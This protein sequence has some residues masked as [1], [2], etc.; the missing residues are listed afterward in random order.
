MY[1]EMKIWRCRFICILSLLLL[2]LLPIRA[3]AQLT[4]EYTDKGVL[5]REQDQKVLFYQQKT[6]SHLGNYPRANYIHPLYSLGGEELTEDFP[7]DHLHHRGVF[8]TWHQ[9]MIGDS[10]IGDAWSCKDFEWIVQSVTDHP[11]SGGALVLKTRTLWQSP[12]WTGTTGRREPMLSEQA[13]ITIHPRSGNYRVVDFEIALL[14]LVPGLKIGGSDDEKG[15]GG[16]SVRVK[17]PD[18]VK[19]TAASG[20]VEPV[21]EAIRAGSWM[22]LSGAMVS[23]QQKTGILIICHPDNPTYPEPWILR[24]KNSMQN[25]VYPGRHPVT[26]SEKNPTTL[27][28]R[29][30]IIEGDLPPE[31]LTR[32]QYHW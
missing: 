5:I 16:F 20:D 25:P 11:E 19:F 9:V 10:S 29:L 27:R 30:V 14:A 32:L 17:L 7:E 15:Y 23:D 8:W 28:Y 3:P 2:A 13:T 24:R 26:V 21:N 1:F 6:K 12:R 18:D 4:A 31:D 22:Q